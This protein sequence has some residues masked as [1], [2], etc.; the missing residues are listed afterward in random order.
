[1]KPAF[2]IRNFRIYYSGADRPH[3]NELSSYAW[4]AILRGFDGMEWNI[5]WLTVAPVKRFLR[6]KEKTKKQIGR[7]DRR[8]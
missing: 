3:R 4:N 5:Y 2:N 8:F 1:M 6:L 7:T